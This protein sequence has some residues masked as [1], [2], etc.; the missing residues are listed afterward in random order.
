MTIASPAA[1]P[2]EPPIKLK[3]KTVGI[4]TTGKANGIYRFKALN[5][6]DGSERFSIYTGIT[7]SNVGVSTIETLS[8]NQFNAVK[9]VVE[10]SIGSS[11]AVS[12][13]LFLH[14]GSNAYSQRSGSL[15]LTKD[16]NTEYDPS[17]GLGTFGASISGSN[18]KLEFYHH[19]N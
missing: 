18:F 17:S 15:S 7:S 12:E 1:I 11:K 10:V 3:S 16:N 6:L 19:K 13:V 4:G 14:D 8:K 9:S 5:Q 2:I